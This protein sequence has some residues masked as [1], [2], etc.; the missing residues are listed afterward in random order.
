MSALR[1]GWST[2]ACQVRWA[3]AFGAS[4]RELPVLVAPAIQQKIGPLRNLPDA[5]TSKAT[6]LLFVYFTRIW[7][8]PLQTRATVQTAT[9]GILMRQ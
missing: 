7:Y 6:D 2:V 8:N 5:S 3:A 9:G 4:P 1:V